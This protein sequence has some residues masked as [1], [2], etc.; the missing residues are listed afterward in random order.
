MP[1]ILIIDDDESICHVLARTAKRMGCEA[2]S[3][4]TL[5]AGLQAARKT[6][7]DVVFLDI[8]LPDG[9]GLCLLADLLSMPAKPEVI[10]V[11][12]MGDP[13]GAELAIQNGAWDYIEKSYS[14][15]Q[16]SLS[17]K[18]AL[19]YRR[20][21]SKE[22][23][24]L[25]STS[26]TRERIIGESPALMRALNMV[27]QFAGEDTNVLITGETGTGKELFAATIHQNS[28][29]AAGPFIAVDC[30]TL[31]ESLAQSILFGHRKGSFTGAERDQT[32]LILQA[33]GG[34]LFLDEIGELS[35]TVQK[36]FLRVL[37]ERTIRALG[38]RHER[39]VDFRLIAATNR[40]LDDMAEAGSFRV[41]LLYRLRAA[42]IHL[43]PLRERSGD[44]R[45]L[46]E[47]FLE[48]LQKKTEDAPKACSTDFW[49]TLETYDWPGNV[50]ELIHTLEY[51]LGTARHDQYLFPQH[52]PPHVRAKVARAK[53]QGRPAPVENLPE[54]D[55]PLPG[56]ES[57]P[58]I[59]EFRDSVLARA[60]SRYLQNLITATNGNIREVIRL[61]GL[62][63]SRL[64]ALLKKYGIT[65]R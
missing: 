39:H 42:H 28:N 60:E 55:A 18:R 6:S 44:I 30:A 40:N 24:K 49:E 32:G 16:I 31:P 50:R 41:D 13:A 5:A 29:R 26:L 52:L 34:T 8:K 38:D 61:S 64:Y 53:V 25:S 27:A 1:K 3:V 56:L 11:T 12:G 17:L 47:H 62:S 46:A 19:E 7:F 14:I 22:A 45:L 2:Q 36:N 15:E 9:N 65:T 10:I 54:D 57:I 20:A 51:A 48:V 43:P 4:G 35:P 63:Q 58:P 21:R 37:Q 59:Q 23:T 33:N